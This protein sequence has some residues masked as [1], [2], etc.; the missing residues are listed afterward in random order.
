VTGGGKCCTTFLKVFTNRLSS[1]LLK[2]AWVLLCL[3]LHLH[4]NMESG[5]VWQGIYSLSERE[6]IGKV[7]SVRTWNL[8]TV[9]INSLGNSLPRQLQTFIRLICRSIVEV[10]CGEVRSLA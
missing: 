8:R 9:H 1:K 6:R 3:A 2:E 10:A 4:R 7:L 5:M